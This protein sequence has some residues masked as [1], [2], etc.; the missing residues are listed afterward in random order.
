M[1]ENLRIDLV[2]TTVSP[3]DKAGYFSLGTANDFTSTVARHSKK[4]IVEVNENMPRVFGDSLLHISEVA[5]IV[6]NHVPL[7]EVT[8][9]K[10]RPE[11]DLIGQAVAEIIPHGATLQ[12][13][14][15]N[16]PNSVTRYLTGHRNLG[17][18]TEAFSP[19]MVDLIEK[20]IVTGSRKPL[21]PRKNVFTLAMG[22]RATYEF[23]KD[24]PSME[25]Y[26][27]SYTND[28]AI[29][30]K[31]ERMIPLIPFWRW[32]S[33]DSAIPNFSGS[34][35]SVEPAG[36]WIMFGAHSTPGE[37][38]QYWLPTPRQKTEMFPA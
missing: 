36:N 4:L 13:G 37:E 9:A 19:G 2:V 22:T 3:M 31:N 8:P 29:V 6:E 16:I 21:H 28:P 1:C 35:N 27:V 14:V 5:A 12:L 15:G 30:A 34:R 24:N 10:P 32:I 20:V 33:R 26:P 38:S 11:D 17:I 23:M 7:L 18:H 25:S